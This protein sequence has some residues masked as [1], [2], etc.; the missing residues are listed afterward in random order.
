MTERK[1]ATGFVLMDAAFTADRKFLRL[2]RKA[3]KPLDYAA[4][5]GVF[6]MILADAR[7]VK[8][9]EV[10]WDEYDEYSDQVVLL[11][12]VKLLID[13]GFDPDTF[14]KWAPS[15]RSPWD[16]K[17]VRSGTERVRGNTDTSGQ[18]SSGQ[19]SSPLPTNGT[20]AQETFMGFP[21]KALHDGSHPD[22][23]VCRP[24]ERNA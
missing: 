3:P 19:V 4:A 7:R 24:L 13:T 17:W 6:W 1:R 16:D 9:A 15:Y 22:C 14:K 18:V 8:S 12:E 23:I 10:N 21:P 11:K 2:S 20:R 5:V